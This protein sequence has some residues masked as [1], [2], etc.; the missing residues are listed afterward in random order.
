LQSSGLQSSH[1]K[2]LD[3]TQKNVKTLLLKTVPESKNY[4]CITCEDENLQSHHKQRGL[5]LSLSCAAN[6]MLSTCKYAPPRINNFGLLLIASY[7]LQVSKLRKKTL[8][9]RL[10]TI[11]SG[12]LNVSTAKNPVNNST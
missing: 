10:E 5:V 2:T 1:L 7:K 9:Q 3:K 12:S 6:K 11:E 4:A 8:I